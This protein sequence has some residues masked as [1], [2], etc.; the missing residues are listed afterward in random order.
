MELARAVE[1]S[2]KSKGVQSKQLKMNGAAFDKVSEDAVMYSKMTSLSD[3]RTEYSK[4]APTHPVAYGMP[5]MM[6]YASAAPMP[7]MMKMKRSAVSKE[8]HD[9]D[10]LLEF[11]AESMAVPRPA[12][13]GAM[14]FEAAATPSKNDYSVETDEVNTMQAY[15]MV[16]K[17][18]NS[19]KN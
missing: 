13:P 14:A 15:R 19:K 11:R 9:S 8:S 3:V 1:H 16:Q 5:H 17:V 12:P 6:S 7:M 2:L 10:G 4:K 18:L